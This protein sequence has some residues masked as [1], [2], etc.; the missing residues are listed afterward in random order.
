MKV[1]E[2]SGRYYGFVT[3][4]F[5][6][7]STCETFLRSSK[8]IQ[9]SFSYNYLRKIFYGIFLNAEDLCGIY[10]EY[11]YDEYYDFYEFLYKKELLEKDD[12]SIIRC[13][14]E[15][16][17]RLLRLYISD[18]SYNLETFMEYEEDF[19]EKFNAMIQNIEEV[20][21]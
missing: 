6:L 14:L 11:Y 4:T 9:G 7:Y 19:L 12:I 20:S 21:L 13:E 18:N 15:K 16:G 10:E 1:I 5:D 3:S 2:L 17:L 8:V